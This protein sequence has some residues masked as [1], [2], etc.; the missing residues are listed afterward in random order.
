LSE[1]SLRHQ[2]RG[3]VFHHFTYLPGFRH[4]E[5]LILGRFLGSF[6]VGAYLGCLIGRFRSLGREELFGGKSCLC[7]LGIQPP[8]ST[9]SW[10]HK[11]SDPPLQ[12]CGDVHRADSVAFGAVRKTSLFGFRRRAEKI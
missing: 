5:G 8:P 3:S 11:E 2:S 1:A 9:D 6:F 10:S 12:I 7:L 4:G